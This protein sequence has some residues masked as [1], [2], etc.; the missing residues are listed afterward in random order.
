MAEPAPDYPLPELP[1][2]PALRP[3]WRVLRRSD[4]VLQIGVDPPHRVVVPDSPGVREVLHALHGSR[5]PE[6]LGADGAACLSD[7]LAADL[8]VDADAAPLD[9]AR[10]G[11]SAGPRARARS[12]TGVRVL[13]PASLGERAARAL[14]DAGLRRLEPPPEGGAADVPAVWL[15]LA[16]GEPARDGLDDLVRDDVPHLVVAAREGRLEIGP[17]VVPG[18]TACLRCVDA[19]RAQGDPRRQLVVEQVA[20]VAQVAQPGGAAHDPVLWSWATAWAARDLARYAEGDRPSTWSTT[21]V[22]DSL[23]APRE[24]RWDRHP[25]CGCSWQQAWRAG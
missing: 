13:A 2:H 1:A 8:V 3:G 9:A 25:H 15:V 20:Q 21:F 22:V 14:D 17:F 19:H 12:E 16:E 7:L 23:A 4:G 11:A 6:R 18:L 24:Q 5:R 10:F